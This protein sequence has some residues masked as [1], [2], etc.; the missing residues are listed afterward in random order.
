MRSLQSLKSRLASRGPESRLVQAALRARG[1]IHGFAVKF[2]GETITLRRKKREMI[3]SKA[4]YVQVPVMMDAYD[5][6][7][8]TIEP[9][10]RGG[11]EI[12][13]FSKP[14]LQKYKKSG[15]SLYFPSVPE[16]DVMDVYTRWY[17]PK[18]GDVVWDAGAHVGTTTCL[19]SQMVGPSGK[20]Y[21]FEP[22]DFNCAYLVRNLETQK[23]KNVEL[24]REALAGTT[25]SAAFIMDGTMCAGMTDYLIYREHEKEKVVPTITLVDACKKTGQIPA[26][27]KMDIE[28]AEVAV[29]CA[30][31]DFLMENH[32]H[33]AIESHRQ[34]DGVHTSQIL[35]QFFPTVGY[36]VASSHWCGQL[37]T[38]ARPGKR[39][40]PTT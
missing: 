16:D 3:L 10:F 17:V 21:A 15:L 39:R 6:F 30:A 32:I 26:Y 40:T 5:L 31:K 12:L 9:T 11:H 13:D 36:E 35:E 4:Q 29:I 20:V 23:L 33:F 28:G 18:A 37:F 38:W 14:S 24:L 8:N 19:L 22:D 2:S 27:I 1:R 7:F 34:A 25:G